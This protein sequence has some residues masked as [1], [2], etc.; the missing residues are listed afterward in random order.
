M[1]TKIVGVCFSVGGGMLCGYEEPL[2]HIGSIYAN[3][4]SHIPK[5]AN[6]LNLPDLKVFRNDHDKRDFVCAGTAAGISAAF[7]APVGGILFS[8]EASSFWSV[9]LIRKVFICSCL[10]TFSL[11]FCKSVYN[12]SPDS[13]DNPGLLVFGQDSHTKPF[14]FWELP[15]WIVIG[16]IG[17]LSGAL[18][19]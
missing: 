3:I 11:N 13:M 5:L 2:V 18:F 12:G 9:S 6:W 7:G 14:H 1:A 16:I 15:F 10:S 8:L 17:G 19:N 4:Y